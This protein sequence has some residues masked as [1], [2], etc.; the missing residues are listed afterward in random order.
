MPLPAGKYGPEPG[1]CEQSVGGTPLALSHPC[2]KLCDKRK[3]TGVNKYL[4]NELVNEMQV[5]GD[6]WWL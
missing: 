4:M 5:L 2:H 3:S 1:I 6:V